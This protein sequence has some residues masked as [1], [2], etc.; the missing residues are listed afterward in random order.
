MLL[1]LA[2]ASAAQ[3]PEPLQPW[4][5]WVL[6]DQPFRSCPVLTGRMPGESANHVC[7]W[8]GELRLDVDGRGGSFAQEW[9]LYAQAWLPLPGSVDYWPVDVR[10]NGEPGAVM[11]R[12][13][14]PVIQLPP[15]EFRVSGGLRWEGRPPKLTLPP[16]TGVVRLTVDGVA[17]A[18]PAI[19]DGGIWLAERGAAAAAEERLSVAVYRLLSD[20]IPV[21]LTTRI[22]LQIAGG[23]REVVLPDPLLSGF[24]AQELTAGLP[25]VLEDDGLRLQLR[26]GRFEVVITALS[27]VI[28]ATLD[29]PAR[30][31]PWPPREIWSFA[32]DTR[33]RVATLEGAMPVDAGQ[34]G[35]PIQWRGLP[36]FGVAGGTSLR[37]TERSRG[38]ADVGNRLQ[39]VRDLWLDFD[40]G[41]L[42]IR[43]MITGRQRA[44]RLDMVSPYQMTSA[45]SGSDNLL[46]TDGAEAGVKGVELRAAE[47]ALQTSARLEQRNRLFPTT[48]YASRF[49]SVAA[50]L[51]LPPGYR[52]LAARGADRAPQ[53]WLEQWRLLDIFLLLIVSIAALRLLG[54]AVGAIALGS[55]VITY[56]EPGSLSWS[57]LWLLVA[58]AL[59]RMAPEGKL[60]HW[61]RRLLWLSGAVVLLLLLP[62]AATQLKWILFPQLESGSRV[63]AMHGLGRYH[64][65]AC[66]SGV[67]TGRSGRVRGDAEEHPAIV[68][69]VRPGCRWL[70]V[71]PLPARGPSAD[72]SGPARLAVAPASADL[73]WPGG[74]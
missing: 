32:A 28:P 22:Q 29:P 3:V 41:G 18:A 67:R 23:A 48:G 9:R 20:G 54:P 8:P 60:R 70:S 62:F 10:V 42:T 2:N 47:L 15:G 38:E 68:S 33:L 19:A 59:F 39:L 49:E 58:L 16:E 53:A 56:H 5:N 35:A 46:I 69:G 34:V 40:G 17:I 51:Q 52:L 31:A 57:W 30:A 74:R 64:R 66:R 73:E 14:R 1:L 27:K 71:Q 4:E 72:R 6:A 37:L 7:A 25:A 11:N 43:D 44:G 65:R 24:Q 36:T 55:L 63:E 45:R 50:T 26:P 21:T 61:A 13:G 12:N